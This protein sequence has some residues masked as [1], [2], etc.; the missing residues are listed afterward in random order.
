[1]NNMEQQEVRLFYSYSHKDEHFREQLET[2]LRIL[3]RLGLIQEWHDRKILASQRWK[4]E[5]DRNLE[6][7]DLILLLVSPDFIDSDYCWETELGRAIERHDTGEAQVVPIF[8]RPVEWSGAPFGSLQGLPKDA[9]S[10]TE[11]S[12]EDAAWRNVVQGLRALIEEIKERKSRIEAPTPAKSIQRALTEDIE[13]LDEQYNR[14]DISQPNGISTGLVDVDRMIDGLKK[15]E[16]VVVASRPSMGKTSLVLNIAASVAA[17]LLPVLIFSTKNSAADIAQRMLISTAR[18]R[19][20]DYSRGLM[21]DEHWVKLTH[22]V[23]KIND[24][25]LEIDDTVDLSIDY[26]RKQCLSYIGKCGAVPLVVIDSIAY[27]NSR[28]RNKD[29]ICQ[30]LKMLAKE[31]NT[32]IIVTAQVSR[33]VE[34][35]INKRPMLGDVAGITDLVDEADVLAFIYLDNRYNPDSLDKNTAELIIPKNRFGPM[36]TARLSYYAEYGLFSNFYG[37]STAA[38][39]DT[40]ARDLDF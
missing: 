24:W 40:K 29:G 21:A 10:V 34:M 19:Y 31:L 23:Q 20:H 17:G 18:L 16:L 8:I 30:A 15:G 7:A 13:R 28:Q 25:Q 6:K 5:I 26:L 33:E 35:R 37:S 12:N 4:N 38:P 1:M 32:T 11:W 14:D 27:I 2:H 9:L 36:G 3:H 39:L 22:A